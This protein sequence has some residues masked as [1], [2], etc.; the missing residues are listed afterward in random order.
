MLSFGGRAMTAAAIEPRDHRRYVLR[1]LIARGGQSLLYEALDVHTQSLVAFKVIEPRERGAGDAQRRLLREAA[2]LA[3]WRH[4]NVVGF[5]ATGHD[6]SLGF[7]LALE[8]LRGPT[9]RAALQSEQRP[10]ARESIGWMLPVLHVLAEMHA[11]GVA[12]GD[13]TPSN[14]VLARRSTGFAPR[15]IDFGAVYAASSERTQHPAMAL[16]TPGYR[17]PEAAAI[18]HGSLGQADVWAIG[19]ILFELIVGRALHETTDGSSLSAFDVELDRGSRAELR[20]R[21]GRDLSSLVEACLAT[22]LD[23]RLECAA[24]VLARL[25]RCDL[26]WSAPDSLGHRAPHAAAALT[27]PNGLLLTRL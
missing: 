25:M 18:A 8:H 1:S 4:P 17:A 24:S 19:A 12:H 21:C 14:I 26:S 13:L 27:Q 9:L 22:A 6:A 2:F 3:R 5:R 20:S 16:T 15:L 23:E 7:W 10:S 11:S